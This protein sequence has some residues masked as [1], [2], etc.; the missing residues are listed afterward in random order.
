M[1]SDVKSRA[2][3][4]REASW[5]L[6]NVPEEAKN[7]ALKAMA[8]AVVKRRAEI[9]SANKKDLDA[10]QTLVKQGKLSKALYD[11]L[12]LS[13]SK[14]GA[15]AEGIR[16]VAR[17]PD[18]TGKTLSCTELDAGLT[19]YKVTVPI[20][21]LGIV[22]ESR[23]DAVPQIASLALKSG[24]A[25]LMKGGREADESNKTLAKILVEA[26]A[27]VAEIPDGWLQVLTSREEVAQLLALDELVDLMIP[28][29]SNQF[30]KHIMENTKIPVLGHAA[31]RCHMY[32]D[33]KADLKMAENL[34][35]D[36]KCQ[37]PAVCNATETILVHKDVAK[38]FIPTLVKALSENEVE[39]K[40]STQ[41][42]KIGGKKVK[43][44]TEEDYYTEYNDLKV[45]I[46]TVPSLTEAIAHINKYGSH[47]TDA[48]IT[49]D[50]KAA[51]TFLNQTDS[52]SVMHNAS[53]RFADGYRYGLGAEIGISTNKIHAR[54]PVGLEGLIIYK[55]I[56]KG[57][58]Q[59]VADYVGE[60][61]RKYVH[62][63]LNRAWKP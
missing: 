24:N 51:S 7:K 56:L 53:T 38:K 28:R 37:Y 62:R 41:V 17:L 48:I 63:P 23:P 49:D 59:K 39:I 3:K 30:V 52:A 54:G 9:L 43:P 2:K 15:I 61:A 36:A 11:R 57:S 47:H 13:E 19:L 16:S 34:C 25:V 29:G 32:V 58:G 45:N 6:A 1:K 22:F 20:G 4:A 31:G 33:A 46:K 42:Q 10:A 35:V 14:I 21:V 55:W 27:S 18:P 26:A 12:K 44:A 8:D 40:G 50:K 5:Q 60:K